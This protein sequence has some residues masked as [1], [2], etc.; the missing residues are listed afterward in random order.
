MT[1]RNYSRKHKPI[2]K[3]SGFGALKRW[4]RFSKVT[5]P[6]DI[7]LKPYWQSL[8]TILTSVWNHIDKCLKPYWQ[9][10]ETILTTA[11]NYIYKCWKPYLTIAWN[12]IDIC[13]KPYWQVGGQKSNSWLEHNAMF[14]G[15][16]WFLTSGE[17]ISK[18]ADEETKSYSISLFWHHSPNSVYQPGLLEW[19]CLLIEKLSRTL[20]NINMFRANIKKR[21]YLNYCQWSGRYLYL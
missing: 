21:S 14:L 10:P 13:L 4:I 11:G 8:E 20:S 6:F 16:S 5:G 1:K 7:C 19:T 18:K 2:R 3:R 9:L 17:M 12:H 15:R